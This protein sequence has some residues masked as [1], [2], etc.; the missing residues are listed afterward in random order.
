MPDYIGKSGKKYSTTQKLAEGGEGAVYKISNNSSQVAKIYKPG[1]FKTDAECKTMERK[2]I[3]MLSFN[4][5][6][7]VDGKLRLAWPQDILYQ[8]GRIFP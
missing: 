1:H 4:I 8:N 5:P 3:A 2:L 6:T 7:V